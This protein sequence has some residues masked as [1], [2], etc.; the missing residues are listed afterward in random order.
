MVGI[1]EENTEVIIWFLLSIPLP[2]IFFKNLGLLLL[3]IFPHYSVIWFNYSLYILNLNE[4]F[5]MSQVVLAECSREFG[6]WWD[7]CIDIVNS[8]YLYLLNACFD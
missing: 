2:F 5:A 8:F 1:L 6:P 7:A 3:Y 4:H